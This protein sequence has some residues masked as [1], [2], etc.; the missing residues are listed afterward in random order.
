MGRPKLPDVLDKFPRL[1]DEL[2]HSKKLT[3]DDIKKMREMKSRCT[4]K[5]LSEMFKVNVSTVCYWIY[6]N[7]RT[8]Q[9]AKNA[10]HRHVNT[11]EYREIDNK[12]KRRCRNDKH[13]K[14]VLYNRWL[15]RKRRERQACKQLV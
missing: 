5:E 9:M 2:D 6:P 4:I 15:T 12:N 13:E 7:V 3:S 8:M 1:P 11:P 14:F 10:K